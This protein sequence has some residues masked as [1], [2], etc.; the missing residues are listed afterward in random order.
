MY[1]NANTIQAAWFTAGEAVVEMV[2][3]VL[4]CFITAFCTG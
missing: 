4:I 2:H 1:A 3:V